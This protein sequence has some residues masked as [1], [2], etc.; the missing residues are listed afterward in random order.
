[1]LGGASLAVAGLTA[2]DVLCAMGLSNGVA[3][4]QERGR[5][6]RETIAINRSPED[7]YRFWRN[8]SNLPTVMDYLEHVE[9]FDDRRSRWVSKAIG[10]ANLEW[11]TE[12]VDDEP[13]RSI[14]WRSTPDSQIETD[15]HVT[16]EPLSHGRGTSVTVDMRFDAPGIAGRLLQPFTRLV[17]DMAARRDLRRLKQFMETGEV[18]TT[19]GQPAGRRSGETW[20]DRAVHA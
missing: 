16:F 18:S 15:G 7:I 5:R 1:M 12:V 4:R 10:A 14:S 3:T 11:Q 2:V 17:A 20:L 8:F 9:V 19:A 13:N 6:I